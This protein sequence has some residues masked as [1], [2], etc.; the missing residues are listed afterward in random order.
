[1]G[2]LSSD[3]DDTCMR[4]LKV[5]I[6]VSKKEAQRMTKA[7]E[8]SLTTNVSPDT[9]KISTTSLAMAVEVRGSQRA[10]GV[11]RSAEW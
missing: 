10:D 5:C 6:S 7:P 9:G 3:D 4:D 11:E 8:L 2:N 1:M